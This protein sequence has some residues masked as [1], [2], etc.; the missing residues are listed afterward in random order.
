MGVATQI[1]TILKPESRQREVK[2]W[3][4]IE[5]QSIPLAVE[6][7]RVFHEGIKFSHDELEIRT[8]GS[9]GFDQSVNLVAKIPIADEWIEGKRYLTGLRGQSISIPIGGTVNRPVIDR[10]A[11]QKLSTD[12]VRN[13]AQ[14][15]IGNAITDKVNPKLNEYRDQFNGKVTGE[16]NKLQNKFQD[17][18]GGFLQDKLGVPCLL[19]TSPSPRDLSTS[20]MPSS[21]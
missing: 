1:Q 13:A 18:L 14:G 17:K 11:V 20:R 9:V 21:A 15:A 19:Y 8:S 10:A 4:K 12:L 16:V 6:N 5:Q 2:T 7:G 3:L